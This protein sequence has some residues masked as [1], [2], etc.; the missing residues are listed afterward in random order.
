MKRVH[1][2]MWIAGCFVVAL[3]CL[4][5]PVYVIRPFRPQGGGELAATLAVLR[6][7][8][9]VLA[10]AAAT[11]IAAA[12]LYWRVQQRTLRRI[13]AVLGVAAVC[14]C[15]ALSRINVYEKMFH[16]IGQPDFAAAGETKLEGD[17]KVL[18][19]AEAGEARA[20][21]VRILAYHHVVNDVVGGVPIVATY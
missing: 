3:F 8:P 9:L 12:V 4:V 18:A 13:G 5:Y 17:E 19:I 6:F 21:P 11:S 20:Y 14:V 15:G 10:L 7:R 2:A 1:Y 16:P